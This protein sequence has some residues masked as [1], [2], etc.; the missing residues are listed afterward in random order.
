MDPRQ[1]GRN[2]HCPTFGV[3]MTCCK[4]LPSLLKPVKSQRESG[5]AK[6]TPEKRFGTRVCAYIAVSAYRLNCVSI[7]ANTKSLIRPL[8]FQLD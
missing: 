5:W 4:D 1:G 7:W 2:H 6:I 8:R 3:L